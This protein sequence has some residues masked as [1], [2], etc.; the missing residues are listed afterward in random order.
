VAELVLVTGGGGFIASWCIAEL[1]RQGFAVRA[2]VR[3]ADKQAA[4]CAA[5]AAAGAAIDHLGFAVAD[6]TAD[7]GWDAATAG[8]RY[9]LHV[10]S[11]LG[12]GDGDPVGPARDGTLRVLRAATAAGVERVVMTSAA[13]AARLPREATGVADETVWADPDDPRFDAY[14]RSKILAERAAWDY[15]A[16]ATGGTELTTIL[17][18]AVFGPPLVPGALGSLQIID[19]ML[20]G[21]LPGL[22]R[23]AL[24]IVDVRDLAALHVRAM[25]DPAAANQRF[26]ATG[27]LMW[28]ADIA[29]ALRARLGDRAAKVPTRRLPDVLVRGLS[30]LLPQLRALTPELGRRND[31]SSD[32]A[33]RVLGFAPR[34]AADTIADSATRLLDRAARPGAT[35]S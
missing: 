7:A 21:K 22:P 26:L 17:P 6:L 35:P 31:V 27:E 12:T 8:C 9:A 33:R 5:L 23:L 30:V 11:P 18:G 3:S 16:T 15:L 34:P 2:T 13:A 28:M 14:R 24:W 20:A 29:A 4:L 25:T 1:L 32:K 19:R 10:A